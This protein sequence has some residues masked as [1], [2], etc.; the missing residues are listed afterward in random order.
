MDNYPAEALPVLDMGVQTDMFLEDVV[1]GLRKP[2]KEVPSKYFYDRRG[3]ALFDEITELDEYYPTRTELAIMAEH[4]NEM[5]SA[6][7]PQAMIVE[8]GSGS[9]LKTRLLLDNLVD[10]VAYVPIDISRGY[11]LDAAESLAVSYPSIEVLPVVADYTK[12]L[13]LPHPSRA[14]QRTVGYFPGST[15]GNFDRDAASRFL[16]AIALEVGRGGGLLIGVDLKKDRDVLHRAYNDAKGVTADFSLNLLR[17]INRELGADFDLDR[18]EHVAFW[19]DDKGRI[20]MHLRS[21]V[22]QVVHV[23]G[24]AFR[25]EEGETIHTENCHKFTVEEFGD[26]VRPWFE[27]RQVWVDDEGLFSVQYLEVQS[28]RAP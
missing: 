12:G 7:G 17:R 6:V 3:S 20:E 28:S 19:S 27:Q 1:A 22:D 2:Q 8:Y 9:S 25:F 26:L 21:A 4:M 5:V 16:G 15:I 13:E 10:P 24:E 11:L 14:P 18:F 23:G